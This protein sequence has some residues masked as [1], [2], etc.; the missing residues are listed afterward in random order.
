MMRVMTAA[1]ALSG[2][3]QPSEPRQIVEYEQAKEWLRRE[4]QYAKDN[5]QAKERR[6]NM[7]LLHVHGGA[8]G[9]GMTQGARD[10]RRTEAGLCATRRDRQMEVPPKHSNDLAGKI[11]AAE[12]TGRKERAEAVG[13]R[14]RRREQE[15]QARHGPVHHLAQAVRRQDGASERARS[16]MRQRST[17]PPIARARGHGQRAEEWTKRRTRS[18]N[19]NLAESA[20]TAAPGGAK[21][22]R[23]SGDTIGSAET[24]DA[25]SAE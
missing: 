9:E 19:G 16:R 3:L 23:V 2:K 14:R 8:D 10:P 4:K 22:M 20:N 15:P 11:S 17:S 7:A 1:H 6:D 13:R 18:R 25:E 24:A 5:E 21:L 12:D